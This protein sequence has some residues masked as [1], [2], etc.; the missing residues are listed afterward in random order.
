MRGSL[1]W[2]SLAALTLGC[3][4]SK[5]PAVTAGKARSAIAPARTPRDR[6]LL[7]LR[8]I[9]RPSPLLDALPEPER[10]RLQARYA[11]LEP[12]QQAAVRNDDGAL[13]ERW[14][15][16]HLAA[17]GSSPRALYAIA[18]SSAGSEELAGLSL[19]TLDA[20][21]V[22]IVRELARRAALH[23]LRDRAADLAQAA[24]RTALVCRL[25]ARAAQ[26]VARRDLELLAHELLV[27]VESKPENLLQ[28][29]NDLARLGDPAAAEQRLAEARAGA[30]PAPAQ[31]LAKT[32]RLLVSSRLASASTADGDDIVM[33]VARARAWLRLGRASEARALLARVPAAARTR[34]DVAAANAEATSDTPAC[35][36]LPEDVGNAALC[37]V[38]FET[39]TALRDARER[40]EAAWQS[41]SARDDEAVEVYVALS[42]VIPW[43]H[44]SAL[45]IAQ[46]TLNPARA[47]QRLAELVAELREIAQPAPQIAGL[48]LFVEALQRGPLVLHAAPENE[49]A[50]NELASRA[51]SLSATAS[52]HFA[53]A[54][55]LAVAASLSR[56]RDIAPLLDPIAQERTQPGL[57]VPRAALGLWLAA[58][59]GDLKR[60]DTARS[61]LAAIMSEG[62]GSALERA[63]LVLGVSEVDALLDSST[64][65]Y[66]LLS[67]VSGQLLNDD[68]PPDLALR[69]VLDAAGALARGQ[70]LAQAQQLLHSASGAELTP[71]FKRAA[72]LLTLIRGYELV[73]AARAAPNSAPAKLR[74][75]LAAL[76]GESQS[77][78]TTVWFELWLTECAAMERE[79][80]CTKRKTAPCKAAAS[81]REVARSGLDARL[82][83]RARAVLERGALPSGAFEAGFR[84]TLENGLEPLILFDPSFLAVGLPPVASH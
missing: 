20:A 73:L 54:G 22:A 67:R 18:T 43:M 72:D 64:H 65:G 27:S 42:R 58:S 59:N 33:L 14:P 44:E 8:A 17:G 74:A 66:Q 35:P 36:D 11:T 80:E 29:A 3:A 41:G 9:A 83:A 77:E 60:M 15:L 45:G 39:S 10:K 84:F 71:N 38:A 12:A 34:L 76:A 47:A 56:E 31:A 28:W 53:Q 51:L 81:L 57:R 24:D 30:R 68:V 82:G 40:L 55:V 78:A 5:P 61:E 19:G 79:V 70:R 25:I 1:T 32:E 7:A 49:R 16:L 2:L 75:D 50:A 62:Q 52:N 63:R 37:A 6:L 46:G 13:V 4:P 48:A 69:A 23:F 26:T 21:Q